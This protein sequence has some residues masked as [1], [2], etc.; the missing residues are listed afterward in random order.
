MSVTSRHRLHRDSSP[1]PTRTATASACSTLRTRMDSSR[2]ET[3]CRRPHR[4]RKLSSAP[5]DCWRTSAGTRK[6][7][8]TP[9]SVTFPPVAI[10]LS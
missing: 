2:R 10:R 7:R 8:R 1:T 6:S 4:S 5:C 9:S 3:T